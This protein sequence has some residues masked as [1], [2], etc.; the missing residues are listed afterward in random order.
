MS[1]FIED[2]DRET[3]ASFKV[4]L[5]TGLDSWKNLA[6]KDK[7]L[8]FGENVIEDNDVPVNSEET[9]RTAA[10]NQLGISGEELTEEKFQEKERFR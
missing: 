10:A 3:R 4:M 6:A 8:Y 1:K 5:M 9:D 2:L 7:S